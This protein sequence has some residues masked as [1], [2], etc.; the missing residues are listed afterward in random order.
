MAAAKTVAGSDSAGAVATLAAY[1][2]DDAMLVTVIVAVIALRTTL[3][4]SRF[5][6]VAVRSYAVLDAVPLNN[7][8]S[9]VLMKFR[10]ADAVPLSVNLAVPLPMTFTAASLP[11]TVN[12]GAGP[13]GPPANA[14]INLSDSVLPP[15][16]LE[17]RSS[18]LVEPSVRMAGKASAGRLPALLAATTLM[19]AVPAPLTATLPLPLTLILPAPR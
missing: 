3:P 13:L 4:P 8:R 18:P 1:P 9:C 16:A 7:T 10:I 14:R 2:D 15:I 6:S 17:I 11:L 19:V 12:V 5:C